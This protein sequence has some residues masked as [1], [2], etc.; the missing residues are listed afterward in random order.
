MMVDRTTADE[1]P[2]QVVRRLEKAFSQGHAIDFDNGLPD[3]EF[4]E[5]T[6]FVY[7]LHPSNEL[8]VLVSVGMVRLGIAGPSPLLYPW[9]VDRL[10]GIDLVDGIAAMELGKQLWEKHSE[11]LIAEATKVRNTQGASVGSS[12]N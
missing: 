2:E 5:M 7:G 9:M 1:T 6:W 12:S 11:Q 4:P 3:K 10:F 8:V